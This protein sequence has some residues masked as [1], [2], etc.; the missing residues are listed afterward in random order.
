MLVAKE[1]RVPYILNVQRE[2]IRRCQRL[3]APDHTHTHL[4]PCG[5]FAEIVIMNC[6]VLEPTV[7]VYLYVFFNHYNI[8]QMRYIQPFYEVKVL[9]NQTQQPTSSTH[10]TKSG[11]SLVC[12]NKQQICNT[13]TH[14]M[15]FIYIYI[16]LNEYY[17]KKCAEL[18]AVCNAGQVREVLTCI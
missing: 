4:P 12:K 13:I 5:L 1:F 7:S 10:I 8:W 18:Y 11:D 9:S 2:Y 15:N 3:Q 17:T 14:W 16:I 6:T